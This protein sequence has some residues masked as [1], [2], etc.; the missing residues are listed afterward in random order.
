MGGPMKI[1]A[2]AFFEPD[3]LLAAIARAVFKLANADAALV[4]RC[5]ICNLRM[6]LES[7]T[8]EVK[9]RVKGGAGKERVLGQ[10][11]VGTGKERRRGEG[12]VGGDGG[13]WEGRGGGRVRRKETRV[14]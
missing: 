10:R 3:A 2:V 4:V 6:P 12:K 1:M 14:E 5:Q 11:N 9:M 8:R 7:Q 13:K